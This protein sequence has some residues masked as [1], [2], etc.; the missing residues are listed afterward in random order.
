MTAVSARPASRQREARPPADVLQAFAARGIDAV[1]AGALY[2]RARADLG[3]AELQQALDTLVQ[4]R[5]LSW[6]QCLTFAR[7]LSPEAR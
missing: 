7:L 6:E 4:T 5:V 1:T 2:T 3:R